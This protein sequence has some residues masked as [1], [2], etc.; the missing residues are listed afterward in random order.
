MGTD[1]T[2]EQ[3]VAE[4]LDKIRE[5]RRWFYLVRFEGGAPSEVVW[6][7]RSELNEFK[8]MVAQFE[9]SRRSPT[10]ASDSRR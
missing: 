8:Q 10:R 4:S 3:V 1:G 5:N 7:Q 6:K 9:D 2:A